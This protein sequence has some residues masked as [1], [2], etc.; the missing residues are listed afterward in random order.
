VDRP[1]EENGEPSSSVSVQRFLVDGGTIVSVAREI[2]G[3]AWPLIQCL[4]DEL[5]SCPAQLTID[6]LQ[7]RCGGNFDQ[8]ATGPHIHHTMAPRGPSS[9]SATSRP[10]SHAPAAI[11][12]L[13]SELHR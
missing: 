6:P 10:T 4:A 1:R 3:Q 12:F 9:P 2:C 5:S 8:S 7:A 11:V 13:H